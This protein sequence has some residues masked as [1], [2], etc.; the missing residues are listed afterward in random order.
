MLTN[1]YLVARPSVKGVS[2][3]DELHIFFWIVKVAISH[4]HDQAYLFKLKCRRTVNQFLNAKHHAEMC[5]VAHLAKR[6]QY[7]KVSI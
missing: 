3:Y 5:A 7:S 6:L 4:L 2:L 1:P